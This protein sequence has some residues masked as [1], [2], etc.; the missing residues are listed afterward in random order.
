MVYMNNIIYNK[1]EES[2]IDAKR[3]GVIVITANLQCIF[4]FNITSKR[5]KSMFPNSYKE[6]CKM[7]IDKKI[8][9]SECVMFNDNGFTLALLV[10]ADTIIGPT[11]DSE[12]DMSIQLEFALRDL[13][14][15]CRKTNVNKFYSGHL[16]IKS[17]HGLL[18]SQINSNEK[19]IVQLD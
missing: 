5:F 9:T 4:D 17:G 14:N 7:V 18:T 3:D 12:D 19:W 13:F 16:G 8:D 2:V 15:T 11:K 10:I 1:N 6:F